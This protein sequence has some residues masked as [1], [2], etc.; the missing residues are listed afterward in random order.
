MSDTPDPFAGLPEPISERARTIIR[1]LLEQ[2]AAD[3]RI[4]VSRQDCMKIVPV[5][6]S[7]QIALEESGEYHTFVDGGTRRILVSSIYARM[8]RQIMATYPVDGPPAKARE[9]ATRFKKRRRAP[10][11]NELQGLARAN[12]ARRLEAEQR[13]AAQA[14]EPATT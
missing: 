7:K 11:P 1:A 4:S 13:R 8:V 6:L 3:P 9:V 12:E 2:Q 5:G 10:T 14:S